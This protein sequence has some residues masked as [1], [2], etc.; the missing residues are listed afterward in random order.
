MSFYTAS[1]SAGLMTSMQCTRTVNCANSLKRRA[2]RWARE[3]SGM[4]RDRGREQ[5]NRKDVPLCISRCYFFLAICYQLVLQLVY[6]SAT[7]AIIYSCSAYNRTSSFCEPA[8]AWNHPITLRFQG[9]EGSR[10]GGPKSILFCAPL[11]SKTPRF[12]DNESTTEYVSGTN[13]DLLQYCITRIS[14]QQVPKDTVQ[15]KRI[16]INRSPTQN[17]QPNHSEIRPRTG[18]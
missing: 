14:L 3:H 18:V 4:K 13:N 10:V 6:D 16:T 5:A 9:N 11:G 1:R 17:A 15:S 8:S 7:R 2:S 12:K